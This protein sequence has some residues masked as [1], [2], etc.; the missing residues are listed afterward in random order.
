MRLLSLGIV[1]VLEGASLAAG[2]E[3]LIK[4]SSNHLGSIAG[5]VRSQLTQKPGLPDS[6]KK[7]SKI[8]SKRF[9]QG[10]TRLDA[11]GGQLDLHVGSQEGIMSVST[12][13]ETVRHRIGPETESVEVIDRRPE[14]RVSSRSVTTFAQPE[15]GQAHVVV[16]R[17]T[18]VYDRPSAFG[19]KIRLRSN[20]IRQLRPIAS[21]T[22]LPDGTVAS[23]KAW[24]VESYLNAGHQDPLRGEVTTRRNSSYIVD[25]DRVIGKKVT[26]ETR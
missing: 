8:I 25:G 4:A 24:A 26:S 11:E 6:M 9:E 19:N 23:D 14:G 16:Q 2:N 21:G 20:V 3:A 5:T 1:L 18:Q 10:A 17:S 7:Q 22:Q 12:E 13:P 15:K